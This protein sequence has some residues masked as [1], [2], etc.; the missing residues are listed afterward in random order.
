MFDGSPAAA[1]KDNGSNNPNN[2]ED[3]RSHPNP[4]HCLNGQHLGVKDITKMGR[5]ER[6]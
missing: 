4:N 5:T 2:D 1:E 3:C 6:S